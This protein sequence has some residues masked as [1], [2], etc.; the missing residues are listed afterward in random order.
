M[1]SL[2]GQDR[3]LLPF[4]SQHLADARCVLGQYLDPFIAIPAPQGRCYC[5]REE[6]EAQSKLSRITQPV[7]GRAGIGGLME[8]GKSLGTWSPSTGNTDEIEPWHK[9]CIAYTSPWSPCST[10]CGLGVSTRI[11]N[12]NARCWPEQESRLCNLRPCDVD[13][14]PHIKVGP[15]HREGQASRVR[16]IPWRRDRLPTPVFWPGE[17]HGLY[18]PWG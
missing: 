16:K 10:S 18:S 11:S 7:G 13:L 17:S 4:Y 3:C 2:Q 9:N 8:T 14:R 6:P 15:P 5:S 12:V 1:S